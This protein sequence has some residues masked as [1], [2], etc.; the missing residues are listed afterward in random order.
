MKKVRPIRLQKQHSK[1]VKDILSKF[2]QIDESTKQTVAGMCKT[3]NVLVLCLRI[4]KVLRSYPSIILRMLF[5]RTISVYRYPN[6]RN[7]YKRLG[8]AAKKLRKAFPD[9]DAK[10]ED[11]S[12]QVRKARQP[13]AG[14][15]LWVEKSSLEHF[16][17]KLAAKYHVSILAQ[18]GFGSLSMFRKA[19][20]RAVKRGVRKVL[21]VGDHDPSGLAI[22]DVT[23]RQMASVAGLEIERIALT[24][25]QARQYRLVAIPVKKKDSRAKAY[26][27][28]FGN[29]S[30]E[31]E[32]LSPRTLLRIV[33]RSLK[34]NLPSAFLRELQ[35]VEQVE[36]ISRPLE[37]QLVERLRK[38]ALA[39][40]K[41]GLTKDEIR[42]KLI[43]EF[44]S[45]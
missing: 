13:A 45:S 20:E 8:Y 10:F 12:R 29:R 40:K 3:A 24:V 39:L 25:E 21:L 17:K 44:M 36:K 2:P 23:R 19:L 27:E 30:W 22:D 11:P 16:M 35:E 4:L 41:Q 33:E 38:K 18:R 5:Y 37:K 15:E 28:R 32:S 43:D 9:V 1:T 31:V 34:R 14:I 26:K 42:K 6:D 7:F